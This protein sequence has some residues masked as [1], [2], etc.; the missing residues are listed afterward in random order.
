MHSRSRGWAPAVTFFCP[1]HLAITSEVHIT[2]LLPGHADSSWPLIL[3]SRLINLLLLPMPQWLGQNPLSDSDHLP[4]KWVAPGPSAFRPWMYLAVPQAPTS[5]PPPQLKTAL[6]ISKP[7]RTVYF[8]AAIHRPVHVKITRGEFSICWRAGPSSRVSG[9]NC[10]SWP[11]HG[12][13]FFFN[14][15]SDFNMSSGCNP[16][17][18]SRI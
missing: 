10:L 14:V 15:P 11:R 4:R 16:V 3:S 9:L 6:L 8:K 5:T 1:A 12:C 17:L 7:S 2:C 13:F 18:K